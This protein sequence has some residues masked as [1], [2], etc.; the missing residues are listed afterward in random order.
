MSRWEP[1][2][3]ER[4]LDAALELFGERGYDSVTVAE[5]AE[6]AGLTKRTFFRHF[7]DKREVLFAGQEVLSR[8]FAGAIAAAP[9]SAT[10]AEAVGSALAAAAAEFGPERQERGR[11][12]QAVVAGH[13]DLRERGLLKRATLTAAM[14]GALRERGVR[15]PAAALAAEI[16]GLAFWTAFAR[17]TATG[18][19]RE[20]AAL[21]AEALE[22][23]L[24]ATATLD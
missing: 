17:W 21:A 1:N 20:F 24:A 4:L 13:S 3:R 2:T 7:T 18:N 11:R 16:G 5:I 6:R 22:E 19:E 23:L 8:V 12:V 14:A 9:A 10:P 15:D